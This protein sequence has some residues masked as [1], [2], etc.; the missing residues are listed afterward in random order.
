MPQEPL[1]FNVVHDAHWVPADNPNYPNYLC[2]FNNNSGAGNS[3]VD[4]WNP[5]YS[6][7]AYSLTQGQAYTPASYNYEFTSAFTSNNEGNSQQLPNGNMLVNNSFG[8][9][10]E[11]S[12]TGTQLWTKTGANSSH[13]YRFTKC[14]VRG[15]IATAGGTPAS[16]SAGDPVSLNSSAISVTETAPTYTYSWS[17]IPSGFTSALQNPTVIPTE[18]TTYIVT[19]TNTALGCSDTASV[20][21]NYTTD[22]SESNKGT[23]VSIF[24]NPFT[25]ELAIEMQGN[26]ETVNFEIYNSIGQRL[27]KG[28]FVEKTVLN[29]DDFLSGIYFIKLDNGKVHEYKKIIKK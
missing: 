27:S 2:G 17:S 18:P 23:N 4:I 10:Y 15:P 16:I 13:A 21:I 3:K 8:N 12:A 26:N 22:I 24:P 19:I 6:G 11:V 5:P 7:N 25:N 29:V 14:Q 20:T 9:I 1:F 28:C